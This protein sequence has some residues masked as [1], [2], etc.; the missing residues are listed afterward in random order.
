MKEFKGTKVEWKI[1]DGN[2]ITPLHE[3]FAIAKVFT[4]DQMRLTTKQERKANAN[5]IASAPELLEALQK[6]L[7]DID[8][9]EDFHYDVSEAEQAINKALNGK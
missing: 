1:T 8:M 5:L 6:L 2:Y 4:A 7:K 3:N 9:R